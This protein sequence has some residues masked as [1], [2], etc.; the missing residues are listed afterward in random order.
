MLLALASHI[1][2]SDLLEL[3]LQNREQPVERRLVASAP[4]TEEAVICSE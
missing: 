1:A 2:S 4:G 3:W